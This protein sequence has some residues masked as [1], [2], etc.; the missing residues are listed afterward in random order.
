MNWEEGKLDVHLR[1]KNMQTNKCKI[2][3]SFMY[4][5]NFLILNKLYVFIHPLFAHILADA[6]N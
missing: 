5:F 3:L 4:F 6:C 1:I 2:L